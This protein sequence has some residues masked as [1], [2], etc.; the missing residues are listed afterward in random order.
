MVQPNND[1]RTPTDHSAPHERFATLCADELCNAAGIGCPVRDWTDQCGAI[2]ELCTRTSALQSIGA[3]AYGPEWTTLVEL[4][5]ERDAQYG[6][7]ADAVCRWHTN[8]TWW[9]G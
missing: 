9:N 5:H 4:L 3:A 2:A 1:E 7:V 8:T 6:D